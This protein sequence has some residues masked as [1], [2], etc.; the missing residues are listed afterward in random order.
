MKQISCTPIDIAG[1]FNLPILNALWKIRVGESFEYSDPKLIEMLEKL[2]EL[3]QKLAKP[4][5]VF[6]IVY[7]WLFKIFPNLFQ[8]QLDIEVNQAIANLVRNSIEQ[9]KKTLDVNSPRDIIDTMLIEIENTTDK[10][11]SFY[12]DV[13][14]NHLV[15]NLIDLLLPALKPHQLPSPGQSSTWLESQIFRERFKLN[16]IL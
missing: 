12:Q 5:G 11:S 9:H 7:P 4:T 1:K 6:A 8:R 2:K 10:E 13:G 16:L 15:N 14:Y 3:F